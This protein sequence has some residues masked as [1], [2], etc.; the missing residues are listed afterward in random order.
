MGWEDETLSLF[1]SL[2]LYVAVHGSAPFPAWA[3]GTGVGVVGGGSVYMG[4]D[5][6]G[7]VALMGQ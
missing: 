5:D 3:V 2:S 1:S 6:R 7:R 4:D